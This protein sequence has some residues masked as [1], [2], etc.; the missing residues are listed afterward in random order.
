MKILILSAATGGGHLR[1]SHAIEKYI[2]ENSV[3][4]EVCV[5][6]ALKS[7]NTVLDKTVCD[8]YHFWLQNAEGIWAALPKNK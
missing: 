5:I 7:I 6:D 8:G 2:M 4:N 3:G 1:A